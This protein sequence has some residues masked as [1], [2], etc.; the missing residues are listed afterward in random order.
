LETSEGKGGGQVMDGKQ[1][2]SLC[3]HGIAKALGQCRRSDPLDSFRDA[4]KRQ[5]A[6]I[7][8]TSTA[9][10]PTNFWLSSLDAIDAKT[11]AKG[12]D[13]YGAV[14]DISSRFS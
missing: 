8:V 5:E 9:H 2:S 13:P 1:I 6:F 12:Q 7:A 4:A 14:Q 10:E 3:G 11:D